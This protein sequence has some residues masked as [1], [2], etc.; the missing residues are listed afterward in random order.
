MCRPVETAFHQDYLSQNKPDHIDWD[1]IKTLHYLKKIE[2]SNEWM[3]KF[4][5]T[6]LRKAADGVDTSSLLGTPVSL[7]QTADRYLRYRFYRNNVFLNGTN[8]LSQL[9]PPING[10]S[11]YKK[12]KESTK[13]PSF[14]RFRRGLAYVEYSRSPKSLI[15]LQ[16]R[17]SR[18]RGTVLPLHIRFI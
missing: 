2:F 7:F 9:E 14:E 16:V 11:D 4:L 17:F 1:I 18:S 5:S 8:H 15:S 12:W 10:E 13:D 6:V 3:A